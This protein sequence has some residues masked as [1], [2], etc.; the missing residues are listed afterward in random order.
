MKAFSDAD[1][2]G[3]LDTRRST[4]GY[5]LLLNGGPVAWGSKRQKCVTIS[6]TESE[7]VAI[8]ETAKKVVWMR[9]ILQHI[10]LPQLSPTPMFCDNKSA[11]QLAK[12]P[13]FHKRTKHIDVKYHY[14]RS[15]KKN[16]TVVI[17]YVPTK[18]QFADLFTKPLN[19]ILFCNL[20]NAISVCST[21]GSETE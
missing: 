6:T 17:T 1:F 21:T 19:H 3:D 14:V 12:N 13:Q 20:R 16:A 10:N 7:Y 18:E 8:C 11:I 5:I 15:C 2:A 9:N 4:T